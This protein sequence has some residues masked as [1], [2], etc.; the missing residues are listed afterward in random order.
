MRTP[1]IDETSR[2]RYYASR[3][4]KVERHPMDGV[5]VSTFPM[6]LQS[7]RDCT[8]SPNL[9]PNLDCLKW[10]LGN[11]SD[12]QLLPGFT[13]PFVRELTLG[14]ARRTDPE[15][16]SM[17]D[18]GLDVLTNGFPNLQFLTVD[19]FGTN[20]GFLNEDELKKFLSSFPLRKVRLRRVGITPEILRVLV[21]KNL[22]AIDLSF[23]DVRH[24]L[25]SAAETDREALELILDLLAAS[26]LGNT[27]H[28]ISI[29]MNASYFGTPNM[30]DD[31]DAPVLVSLDP[32]LQFTDLTFI[33]L[34]VAWV[35]LEVSDTVVRQIAEKSPR[36]TTLC[37][38][39]SHAGTSEPT[40]AMQDRYRT[41]GGI[42]FEGLAFLAISLPHLEQLRVPISLPLILSPSTT[43]V[44]EECKGKKKFPSL[45]HLHVG[46]C[47]LPDSYEQPMMELFEDVNPLCQPE[48]YEAGIS[49]LDG[50]RNLA[51][52]LDSWLGVFR[53]SAN[54]D[55]GI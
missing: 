30:G 12:L 38:M 55:H 14:V 52:A 41:L 36:L 39:A 2:L 8:G 31:F 49:R 27:L 10:K 29:S 1:N 43:Q 18:Y 28:H 11:A 50:Q 6:L 5:D 17:V 21:S 44:L 25:G 34:D 26:L 16:S 20:K 32:L 24:P 53:R 45:R 54:L 3:V 47:I 7:L 33:D 40:T 22:E 13:S 42:S 51:P 9:F 48:T 35:Y 46:Y 19:L 23:Y 4:R 15:S 37:L